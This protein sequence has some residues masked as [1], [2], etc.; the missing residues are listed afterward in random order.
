LENVAEQSWKT[1]KVADVKAEGRKPLE[2]SLGPSLGKRAAEPMCMASD[3]ISPK[4]WGKKYSITVTGKTKTA[5]GTTKQ[6]QTSSDSA[7]P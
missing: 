3:P 4:T 1:M 6:P 5:Q 7:S 2:R